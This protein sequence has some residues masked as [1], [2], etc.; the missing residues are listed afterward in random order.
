[1]NPVAPTL[2]AP[3]SLTLNANG[4][5][6]LGLSETPFDPRDTIA[7][8]VSGVPSDATLTSASH[9]TGVSFN[10]ATQTW[11]VTPA[12]LADLTLN[13]GQAG[14]T[15]LT[16][17]AT[18]TQGVT[19]S[20]TDTIAL[21]VNPV[22]AVNVSV[23]G[24]GTV[25]E[26]QTLVA[27]AT[28]VGDN[29]DAGAPISYQWQSSSDG[30][31]TWSNVGGAVPATFNGQPSSFLQ[32]TEQ[33]E[34]QKFR[35]IASFTDSAHDVITTTSAATVPVADVTPEIVTPF[36]YAVDNL[37][38]VK[39]GTQIYNDNFSQAPIASSDILSNGV[40][41]PIAF[42]TQGSTWVEAGGK[43][44]ATSAGVAGNPNIGGSAFDIAVLNTNTDPTSNLG[45]KANSSFTVSST[46]DLT[47]AAPNSNYGME[48][49]DGTANHGVDQLERLIVTRVNGQATVELI[50]ANLVANNTQTVLASH[51]LTAAELANNTQIEF[52]FSH[53]INSTQVTGSFELINNG[54]VTSTTTFAPA[55]SIF[56]N[57]INWT[58]ADVGAFASTTVALNIA[59]GQSPREGDT[60]IANAAANDSDATLHYQWQS[61]ADGGQTFT[62]IAGANG[63][64]YVAQESDE[65][66]TLRVLVTTTDPDSSQ[67][68]T[69][70]SPTTGVVLDALP[71][72]TTPLVTGTA[73]EGQT[74]TASA[75]AGQG[76]NPVSYAWYSSADG[77]TTAI[78]TGASYLVQE[79]D[80]GFAIEAKATAT[81]DN[82]VGVTA[83]SAATSA[84]LDAAPTVTAPVV[85]GIAQE[86]QTL[87]A[88]ASSGQGDNA[89]T[90]AWYSS[91]DGY[92][93]PIGTG[94]TYLVQEG[95]ENFS[96]EAK[97]TATNDNGVTVTATSAATAPVIDN[98]H[99]SVAVSVLSNGTVQEGQTLQAAATITGDPSDA[100]APVTYQ[101]QS[102]SDGGAT[103]TNVPASATANFNGTLSSLYQLTE[104]DEGKEFRATASFVDDTGQTV[105]ATSP[106][107]VPVADVTPE[108]V[109][110]FSYAVDNLSIV[111]NGTQIYN[112]DFS[113]APIASPD[114]L[115][116]G[117]PTPIAFVTQGS[118]WTEAGGK[119]IASS[120]GVAANP[121]IA[122]SVFDIAVLNTNTDPTSNLG[123]KANASFSVSS[124][125][126]L[127]VPPTGS[128]GM[129]LTDGTATHGV[130]QLERLIVQRVNGAAVV[131]LVQANLVNNNTQTV[132]ASHTLTAAELAGNTQIETCSSRT[133]PIRP[134]SPARSSSSTTAR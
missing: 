86:G 100:T 133:W 80:E 79:G 117:V 6:A 75:S 94:P 108:V 92:T 29:A 36:S 45:L 63:A 71:T 37:S 66:H 134:R 20:T 103:W 8:T 18:N 40:P 113:Q 67:T 77:F 73:Q 93:T 132:L 57:G 87:T 19:A 34:G 26:G 50:Q 131:E 72:I 25:Q 81:N 74:L 47:A 89:V 21:K 124:T 68:A 115:T 111:K 62:A 38:I 125:F 54:A 114:I 51:T 129:E 32:L 99:I 13:A 95:D 52:Q 65:G 105:A 24:N 30:G 127:V 122:G 59:P 49:T 88:S 119:A 10:S 55:A 78:G 110:P 97:A 123:L 58:R 53:A 17:T 85:T 109:V 60:L 91:A 1:M 9:P 42:I 48:L 39:N 46:F 70:T 12:A 56:T 69:A 82:G 28:I 3:T 98:A 121:N 22:L 23:V 101:W 14:V 120:A 41:T 96:I 104:G 130:D 64:S 2:T 126:D 5:V 128:Y 44:V 107:T 43:A 33:N 27:T 118:T 35:A 112:N 61:S 7:I 83:T 90:Y 16:V 116:N 76:D 11:T 4:S 31:A 102:S 15:T 84:V 106:A